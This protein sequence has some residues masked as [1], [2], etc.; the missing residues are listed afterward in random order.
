MFSIGNG[1]LYNQNH[2]QTRTG[3]YLSR[4]YDARVGGDFYFFLEPYCDEEENRLYFYVQQKPDGLYEITGEW[5]I[6][7]ADN[8]TSLD[9]H[10]RQIREKRKVKSLWYYHIDDTGKVIRKEQHDGPAQSYG[11]KSKADR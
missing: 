11:K 1:T 3:Y 5:Y 2:Y 9:R 6:I 8:K 10:K 7:M 4:D